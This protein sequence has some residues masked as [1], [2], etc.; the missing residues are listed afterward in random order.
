MVPTGRRLR[1]WRFRPWSTLSAMNRKLVV[2]VPPEALDGVRDALF[3]AGAGR[4][5]VYEL[6]S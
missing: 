2:F 1:N 3:A 6:V 5:D 4:I